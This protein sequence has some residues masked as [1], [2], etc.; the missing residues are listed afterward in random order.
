MW[1]GGLLRTEVQRPVRPASESFEIAEKRRADWITDVWPGFDPGQGVAVADKVIVPKQG[2]ERVGN[3]GRS[4]EDGSRGQ[5][6]AIPGL[7]T[8]EPTDG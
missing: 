8:A 3:N 1:S 4:K 2:Q 5:Q 6:L 7:R